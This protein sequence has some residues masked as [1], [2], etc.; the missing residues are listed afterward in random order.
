M[1]LV[2]IMERKLKQRWST[3][4]PI[5]IQNGRLPLTL[6]NRTQKDHNISMALELPTLK[7][8]YNCLNQ[9]SSCICIQDLYSGIKI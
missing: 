7:G 9:T 6:N 3:I 5:S 2:R 8:K 1:I 4:L